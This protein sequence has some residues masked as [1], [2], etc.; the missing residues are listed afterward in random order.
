MRLSPMTSAMPTS[1]T[2]LNCFIESSRRPETS[3]SRPFDQPG[4][5][6]DVV[7]RRHGATESAEAQQV[8]VKQGTETF[9][10][11]LHRP[12]LSQWLGPRKWVDQKP[13]RNICYVAQPTDR[14][15]SIAIR[16]KS[17]RDWFVIPQHSP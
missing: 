13:N 17:Q 11:P 16:R 6:V 15:P 3:A 10:Q 14:I 9:G 5:G 2:L 8:L 4:Y 1:K 12:V 7:D